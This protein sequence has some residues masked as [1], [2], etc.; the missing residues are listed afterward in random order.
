MG[1]LGLV[2]MATLVLYGLVISKPEVDMGESIRIM[3]VHV[4]AV[5][6]AY[7]MFAINALGSL[8]W[9][10]RRSRFWDLLAAS[11]AEIGVVLIALTLVTGMLWGRLTWGIYWDWDPRLTSTAVL[12]LAYLG[13]LAT[14]GATL[15]PDSRATRSGVVGL[16]SLVLVPIVH[17]SVEWWRSVHQTSTLK[18]DPL[19]DGTQLFSLFLGFAVFSV[20]VA[21]LLIHRFRVAWL[22]EAVERGEVEEA[23]DRRRV[24]GAGVRSAED[25][26]TTAQHGGR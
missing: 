7:A 19:I 15:D 9:L 3:Y 16:G 23:I 25:P 10:T 26:L 12:F 1:V 2:G 11:A 4:P 22:A 20:V 17:K 6:L 5:T 24:E 13:Y 14:R 18:L 8:L 21:W